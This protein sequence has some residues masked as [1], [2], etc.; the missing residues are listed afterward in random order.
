MKK[1]KKKQRHVEG[2][3]TKETEGWF[4]YGYVCTRTLRV[5]STL[6]KTHYTKQSSLD[7]YIHN[8]VIHAYRIRYLSIKI[9]LCCTKIMN[10]TGKITMIKLPMLFVLSYSQLVPIQKLFLYLSRV[11]DRQIV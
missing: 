9:L 4:Y 5:F 8:F 1:K 11:N 10:C 3:G 7:Q 2:V 6:L